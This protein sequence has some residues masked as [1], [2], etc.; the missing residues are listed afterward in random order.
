MINELH[1]Y[2]QG[3]PH[4]DVVIVGTLEAF[5]ALRVALRR[6]FLTG[7]N[8]PGFFTAD[9]EGYVVKLR[10]VDGATLDTLPATYTDD[11][12]ETRGEDPRWG[13][14]AQLVDMFS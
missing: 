1:V 10:C 9:G 3:A 7:V 8:V 6:F 12:F 11:A 13:V 14:F 2:G 5:D 4:D